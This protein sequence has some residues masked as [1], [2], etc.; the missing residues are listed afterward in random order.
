MN[1]RCVTCGK[2]FANDAVDSTYHYPKNEKEAQIWQKSMGTFDTAVESIEK[3]CCVCIEHIPQFVERTQKEASLI[4][5]QYKGDNWIMPKIKRPSL[6]VLLLSGASL[7][8]CFGISKSGSNEQQDDGLDEEIFVSESSYKD[9]GIPLPDIEATEATVLPMHNENMANNNLRCGDI[10]CLCNCTDVLLLGRSQNHPCKCEA[11][12]Q[13]P[14]TENFMEGSDVECQC[15]MHLQMGGI[16]EQQQQRIFELESMI[17]RQNE[18]YIAL[19]QKMYELYADFGV[20]DQSESVNCNQNNH[21]YQEQLVSA[22]VKSEHEIT[23][24]RKEFRCPSNNM[25]PEPSE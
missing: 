25:Q 2:E 18:W 23:P 19:Q 3:C 10:D 17:C 4:K 5:E 11:S 12:P 20:I 21:P 6:Q 14:Q 13:K 7:S 8:P 16:I 15:Q 1:R 24:N 22:S 9:C